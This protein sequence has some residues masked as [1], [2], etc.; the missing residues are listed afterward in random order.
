ME[1]EIYDFFG[2]NTFQDNSDFTYHSFSLIHQYQLNRTKKYLWWNN[3]IGIDKT[4]GDRFIKTWALFYRTSLSFQVKYHKNR[5]LAMQP[6]LQIGISPYT[7]KIEDN[8]AVMQPIMLGV[9]VDIPY[10]IY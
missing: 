8:E 9:T 6:F 3:A 4:K 1:Q 2:R 5:G 7:Q 10:D